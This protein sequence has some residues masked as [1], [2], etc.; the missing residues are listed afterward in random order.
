MHTARLFAV[1]GL[2]AGVHA[3]AL[4]DARAQDS[5]TGAI[6]GVVRDAAT[7]EPLFA[8]TVVV[9]GPGTAPQ[10]VITEENGRYRVT[11]LPPGNDYKV[12]VY[13]ADLVVELDDIEIQTNGTVTL[14]IPISMET[15]TV[16]G[17]YSDVDTDDTSKGKRFTRADWED[18]PV[19]GTDFTAA[20]TQTPG[21]QN[22][23]F[24]IAVSG[25]SSL[26]SRYFVNGLDTTGLAYGN[27]GTS[28][29]NDFIEEI[30]VVTGGYN[31]EYGRS[32]GG[33]INVVTRSGS[34]EINGS[35]FAYFT[36][37]QLT[38]ARERAPTQATSIDSRTDLDYELDFG[39]EVG[40]PIIKDRAWF[41]FGIAPQLAGSTTTR[42]TKRRT[43]CRVVLANGQLSTGAGERC[44]AAAITMYQDGE[45][46]Q[47]PE[48]GFYIYE[49]LDQRTLPSTSQ[50]YSLLGKINVAAN[51]ENQGSLSLSATPG[52]SKGQR[53]YGYVAEQQLVSRTL[54]ADASF[55][56]TSKLNDSKTELEAVIGVHHGSTRFGSP[57]ARRDG[58]PLQVLYFGSLGNWARLDRGGMGPAESMAT[59]QGCADNT[60]GDPF[61]FIVNCPDEGVGYAIGGPGSLADDM[62]RRMSAKLAAVHRVDLVGNHELK[63]G[64]DIEDNRIRHSRSFSGDVFLENLLDRS[65][66]RATRWVQLADEGID[67]CRDS[68]NGSDY[69]CEHIEAGDPGSQVEG[70]TVNWAAYLRDS[71][72]IRP[73]FTVNLGLR[74]EEQRLRYAEDLQDSRD[75]LTGRQL[76]TNA[77][78]LKNLWAP[79]VGALYDWTREGRSKLYGHWG[80]F[81]ESIPMDINDRAFGGE[82]RYE[83]RFDAGEQCGDTDAGIGG[84]DGMNCSGIPGQGESLFGSGVLVAPGLEPQY[85]D[86][87]LLGAEY[88]IADGLTIGMTYQNRR[89][90]RVIEDVSVDGAATYIIANP[91]EWGGD[92]QRAL[93]EQ[94][95]SAVDP[96]ERERL[97][98]ELA[99]Y[100]GIRIF[101]KPR[102]DYNALQFDLTRRFTKS[103]YLQ[104]SYTYQRTVGNYPGLISYDN[105]QVDP[106]IS[107]QYDLIELLANRDGPLPQDR[108]HYLKLDG[109]YTHDLKKFGAATVGARF[110]ALSGT[111]V[112]VLGR[113]SRY[114]IGETFLLPRGS[115]RRTDFETGL[116]LHGGYQRPLRYGM[117][118]EVFADVFNVFNDQGT[119]SVDE[120][121]TYLS[122]V[123]PISGG[124]YEDL[125]WAKALDEQGLETSAPLTRNPNFG[126]ISARYA[127]L[128]AR[129]GVR[130]TF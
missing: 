33:I 64:V 31:A 81:Y 115:I 95:A 52:T 42:T 45:E 105:G 14:N 118:L 84:A 98:A 9:S 48:T 50:A 1:A 75:P 119:F 85:M 61:A 19:P 80:R 129:F 66:I 116:D 62:E 39:A 55:K 117:S 32:T 126:N 24:G 122:N 82:V 71:W 7:K 107:S 37:G 56:W 127:P 78:V 68:G 113:H 13:Y 41:W 73:H 94:I 21:T 10:T 111:P 65:E 8:A 120:D 51:P 101:D 67:R 2:I 35:V 83:Q 22:D 5:T 87:V 17:D 20:I 25:S 40:G 36:P 49:D 112:D 4:P 58:V 16:Y 26:E 121:Y 23:G 11:A 109:Y 123:N 12:T 86:E 63:G 77:L 106:N 74:Y 46:D 128:S 124:T 38:A 3:L 114:G 44:S 18:M 53:T 92:E 43:D 103:F 60:G 130:L 30:E 28:V 15:F 104:G 96:A 102:R 88:E 90:G 100:R 27:A 70:Q 6:K 125:I 93:E 57:G 79:R 34:N 54:T 89:L 91:G 110:R 99:Q 47:D 97:E 59:R 29:L 108:P 72:Q 76:G 69:A